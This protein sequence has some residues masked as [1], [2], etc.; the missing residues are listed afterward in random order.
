MSDVELIA[1]QVIVNLTDRSGFDN[2][3]GNLDEDIQEEILQEIV[4]TIRK[5]FTK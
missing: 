1:V 2:W 5:G 4:D 3:W